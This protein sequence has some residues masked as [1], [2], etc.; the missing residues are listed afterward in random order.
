MDGIGAAAWNVVPETRMEAMRFQV[1][2]DDH[3][4]SIT[5]DSQ[6]EADSHETAFET[7]PFERIIATVRPRRT[8]L[9]FHTSPIPPVA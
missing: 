5:D 6:I 2:S 1:T 7:E 4:L 3:I 8:F 9:A